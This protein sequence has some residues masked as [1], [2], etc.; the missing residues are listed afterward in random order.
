M[1]RILIRCDSKDIIIN[2]SISVD[3]IWENITLDEDLIGIRDDAT[4]KNVYFDASKVSIILDITYEKRER[5]Y[6]PDT[7]IYLGDIALS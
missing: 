7:K 5:I 4:Q 1:N 3:E 2:T 6:D